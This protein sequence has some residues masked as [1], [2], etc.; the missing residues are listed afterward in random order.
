[1]LKIEGGIGE[2]AD[3]KVGVILT[4]GQGFRGTGGTEIKFVFSH[5]WREKPV[6]IQEALR[7]LWVTSLE[8][9][10]GQAEG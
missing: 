2:S 7:G 10:R 6:D 1:M 4:E 8:F 3:A 5:V 9:R